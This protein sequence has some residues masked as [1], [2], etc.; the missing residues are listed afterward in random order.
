MLSFDEFHA[1]KQRERSINSTTNKK[2]STTTKTKSNKS[3][4]SINNES[5]NSNSNSLSLRQNIGVFIELNQMQ[6]LSVIFIVLDTFI[7]FSEMFLRLSVLSKWQDDVINK[8]F[9]SKA[10][11][12][13]I[14][15]AMVLFGK[16]VRIYFTIELLLI[17][18]AFGTKAFGH[19]GYFV[20]TLVLI[21]QLYLEIMKFGSETRLLNILRLWRIMRF[22]NDLLEIEKGKIET[23]KKSMET[24]EQSNQKLMSD[25]KNVNDDLKREKESKIAIEDMLQNYKEEVDTLN[26]ALKIA[27]MDI[28]EVANDDDLLD[29]VDEL[30]D[31]LMFE[32]EVN[33]D[34]KSD[35][36]DEIEDEYV[37]APISAYDK[38]NNVESLLSFVER[39]L[40]QSKSTL[41]VGL[42]LASNV[43]TPSVISSV[44]SQNISNSS[45]TFVV[46]QDGSYSKV[47]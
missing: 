8:I 24:L 13:Y 12:S 16:Y 39:D 43:D 41:P 5:K 2:S 19:I 3:K 37:D 20:D 26:E 11:L 7:A 28:A 46:N 33:E 44:S 34:I 47:L 21:L 9:I 17:F 6:I 23:F 38:S 42:A 1:A 32:N 36:F 10:I 30:Q 4:A 22:Y 27:A 35:Q 31:D 18:F 14:L 25:L 15:A 40:N 45:K 29:E